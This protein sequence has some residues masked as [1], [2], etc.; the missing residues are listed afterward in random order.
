MMGGT[1]VEVQ[2]QGLKF[3]PDDL[4]VLALNTIE[5]STCYLKNDFFLDP[6]LAKYLNILI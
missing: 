4:K 6:G 2:R 5:I 1:K 3:R